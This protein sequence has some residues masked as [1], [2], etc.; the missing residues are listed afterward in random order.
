VGKAGFLF[1]RKEG[2]PCPERHCG[3]QESPGHRWSE[4]VKPDQIIVKK[5]MSDTNEG[6][7]LVQNLPDR[8]SRHRNGASHEFGPAMCR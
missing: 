7:P 3:A 8:M 2:K 6:V 1:G 4:A 5:K